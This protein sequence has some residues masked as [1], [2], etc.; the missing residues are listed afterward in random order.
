MRDYVSTFRGKSIGTSDWRNHLFSYFSSHKNSST[1]I[2]AL[3]KVDW[4]GWLHGEGLSLP[5]EME[6]D[7]TLA[8]K[9]YALAKKWDASAKDGDTAGFQKTDL[10]DFSSNQTVVFLETLDA[11][12]DALPEKHLELMNELYGFNETTNAE[13][14]L[15]W[16]NVALKGEGKDFKDSAAKWVVTVGRM[17]VSQHSL[18]A[19]AV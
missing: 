7:T 14:R 18:L 16:Y 12:Y 1:I 2:P 17:K 10:D 13:I 19:R 9:A 15:R 6:Y 8:D 3:E 11:K 5:V 4:Q